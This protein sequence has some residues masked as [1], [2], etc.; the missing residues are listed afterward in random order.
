MKSRIVAVLA[1]LSA[2]ALALSACGSDSLD[3]SAAPTPDGTVAEVKANPELEARL[4][5][6]LRASKRIVVG[7][8][9][10]Y[11]PNEFLDTDGRTVIGMNVDLFDAAAAKFGLTVEWQPSGFD[12]I[13]T[14]VQSKKF[15]AGV[16][17]FTINPQRLEQVHMVSYFSAGTQ[18]ATQPGNPNDVDPENP[19]GKTVAVQTGTIQDENDLPARQERCAD[20]PINILQFEGQD[21]A[22]AAVV[23]GRADAMLADSP[24]VAY[25][26][27]Q[28]EDRLE[29]LGDIYEAAPYGIVVPKDQTEFA[30]AIAEAFTELE[31]DG[32]YEQILEKWGTE[33]GAIDTFEVD[34]NVAG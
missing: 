14:G 26:V 13:I 6:D 28:S 8:D 24:I 4:P 3:T 21:Q 25:A 11:A 15:G 19:C 27:K 29:A 23:S 1:G 17:S 34:P 33:Q 18:W 32:T 30:E 16:S 31:A 7:T 12:A 5:E 9:S 2:A 22:T 20:N 10:T